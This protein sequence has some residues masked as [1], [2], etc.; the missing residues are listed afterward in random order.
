MD[1]HAW[2]AKSIEILTEIKAWRQA[3]P[4]ATFVGIEEEVHTRLME[5]EAYILQDAASTSKNRE[6]DNSTVTP[7]PL[8]PTCA[9]PL[10][11][12]SKR[13]RT[14]HGNGGQSVTL[15]RTYGICPR[16]GAGLF[17]PR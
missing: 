10:Q 6:W 13:E 8:C 11:A 12:R 2:H 16:C 7:A 9:V 14:L 3:H 5:L 17:P 4:A 15:P 1:E